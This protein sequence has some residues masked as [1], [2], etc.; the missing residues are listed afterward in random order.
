[1]KQTTTV[2][3][4]GMDGETAGAARTAVEALG[5]VPSVVADR[6]HL[7]DEVTRLQPEAL[8]LQASARVTCT[9]RVPA[10]RGRC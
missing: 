1:M 10:R 7:A 4:V 8:V 9:A 2:L 5:H 6:H 3:L